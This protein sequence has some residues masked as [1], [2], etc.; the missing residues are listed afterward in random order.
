MCS[1]DSASSELE[2]AEAGY[3]DGLM[4]IAGKFVVQFLMR[5]EKVRMQGVRS[6]WQGKAWRL[7]IRRT[8]GSASRVVPDLTSSMRWLRFVRPADAVRSTLILLRDKGG[9]SLA[10]R[11]IS[12]GENQGEEQNNEMDGRN[13]QVTPLT[14]SIIVLPFSDCAELTGAQVV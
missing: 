10:S 7:L 4:C 12:W 14:Y 1:H 9:M 13:P 5:L 2:R 3:L 11:N 8:C 6:N